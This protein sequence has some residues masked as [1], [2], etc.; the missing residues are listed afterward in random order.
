MPYKSQTQERWAH[1][2]AGMKAL[3]GAAKVAE[4]DSASKGL[5]LPARKS[6]GVLGGI[7]P[8]ARKGKKR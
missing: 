4:W 8:K 1:T 6:G 7:R 5:S 3:G 2:S